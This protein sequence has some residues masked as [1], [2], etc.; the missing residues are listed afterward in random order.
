MDMVGRKFGKLTVIR[1]AESK[2]YKDGGWLCK[3]DC[4][5][6]IIAS[7]TNLF[8]GEAI[9]CGCQTLRFGKRLIEIPEYKIWQSMLQRCYNSKQEGYKHYG[10]RGI[11][12]CDQWRDSFYDFYAYMG[13]RPTPK[14]SLDRIDVNGNYEPSNCRWATQKEQHENRREIKHYKFPEYEIKIERF[15]A[16]TTVLRFKD[17]SRTNQSI[18]IRKTENSIGFVISAHVIKPEDV[19]IWT[20]A[21]QMAKEQV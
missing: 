6:E 17:S 21:L 1:E 4:G 5:K 7:E 12:V 3:C 18:T 20:Q 16:N 19:N 11:S 2:L 10:A 14:H 9:G 15:D 8:S 13:S